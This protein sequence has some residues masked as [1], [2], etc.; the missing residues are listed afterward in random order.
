MTPYPSATSLRQPRMPYGGRLFGTDAMPGANAQE[1]G[2]PGGA[3]GVPN[4]QGPMTDQLNSNLMGLLQGKNPAADQADRT[5]LTALSQLQKNQNAGAQRNAVQMGIQPGDPRY[6][7]YQAK[8][9]AEQSSMGSR[10]LGDAQQNRL[11]D[12]SRSLQTAIGFNEGQQRYGLDVS[13]FGEDTRRFDQN[14]G[15][16]ARRYDQDFGSAEKQ[17]ELGNLWDIIN[18]PL[19]SEGQVEAAKQRLLA[20]QGGLD[21]GTFNTPEKNQAQRAFEE[22]RNQLAVLNPGMPPDQL[23]ALARQRFAQIDKASFDTLVKAN[24]TELPAAG[25]AGK[26]G[27]G[28]PAFGN[29]GGDALNL[30]TLGGVS[31]V[32]GAG[33][34]VGE[35]GRGV[36]D[37]GR[38][39]IIEGTGRVFAAPVKGVSHGVMD[40]G[41]SV[42]RTGRRLKNIFS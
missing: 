38:G 15:E 29:A 18:S 33:H 41:R 8:N 31:Q 9:N 4:T 27:G 2:S 40:A 28:G 37:I 23:D 26:G 3:P 34:M 6:A 25:A 5:N 19:S 13:K 16:S 1:Y 42:K 36:R 24:S 39:H 21:S 30:M 20:A 10:L 17:K 32:K 11:D 7:A 12:Q 14:F 35:M 22:V